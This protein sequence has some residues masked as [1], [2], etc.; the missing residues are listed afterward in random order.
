MIRKKFL[1]FFLF[2]FSFLNSYSFIRVSLLTSTP[3][4]QEVYTV[5]GHTAVRVRTDS[6]DVVY[7]YGV[8]EFEDDFVYKFVKGETDYWLEKE[9]MPLTR[10]YAAYKNVNL[11]EQ[12]LNLTVEESNMVYE[13][14]ERNALPENR[15][16]RYNF[17]YDN[18][19]TRPRNILEKAIGRIDYPVWN[20][21]TTY[22]DE[23][24][25]LTQNCQWLQFGID[26][27]LGSETDER[28]DDYALLFLPRYLHDAYEEAKKADGSPLVVS[29]SKLVPQLPVKNDE[30]GWTPT[31]TFWVL[32]VAV[33][34]FTLWQYKK[35]NNNR[36]LDAVLLG[37]YGMVG[38][39]LFFLT[40]VS[41]HPCVNPNFNL[42]WANPLQLLVIPLLFV[43][44]WERPLK[45]LMMANVVCSLSVFLVWAVS[46]QIFHVANIPLILLLVERSLF[47]VGNIVKKN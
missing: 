41:T 9:P 22:R 16:Y 47:I 20:N 38:V 21:T 31:V 39:L 11:F 17:F 40:F 44:K 28:V 34:L 5:W 26:L 23:I 6:V 46:L 29:E 25:E 2:V 32:F 30:N 3:S 19:A 33:T 18:C 8:F 42:L 36:V 7:N 24:H 14:L 37:A 13:A 10:A 4:D 35:K 1:L 12:T 27:C 43:R 15:L 45:C